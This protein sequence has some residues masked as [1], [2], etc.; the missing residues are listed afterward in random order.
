MNFEKM[1]KISKQYFPQL[2]IEY[3]DK[4]LFMKILRFILFFNI[5]FMKFT[6]TMG[7]TIYFPNKQ[8]IADR[9]ENSYTILLHELVHI[10]DMNQI[11]F[12]WFGSLYLFPQILVLL[13]IPVLFFSWKIALFGLIFLLP[14]P[15]YWRMKYERRAYMVSMYVQNYLQNK[16]QLDFM[17]ESNKNYFVRQFLGSNYYWM[18]IFPGIK[19]Q[20]N[21]ALIKIKMGDKPFEDKKLFNIIDDIIKNV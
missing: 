1:V 7:H 2:K 8:Y 11:T 20:F 9:R 6:T 21:D 14:L 13:M 15:A 12:F 18:W 16:L 4:S 17:L 3:K 5:G 19:K 10:Y